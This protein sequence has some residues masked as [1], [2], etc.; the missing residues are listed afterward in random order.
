MFIQACQPPKSEVRYMNTLYPLTPIHWNILSIVLQFISKF[1]HLSLYCL[2]H[3]MT[4]STANIVYFRCY[5]WISTYDWWNDTGRRKMKYWKTSLYQCQSVH[6]K[7]H[8]GVSLGL[9][10]ERLERSADMCLFCTVIINCRKLR[11]H[12]AQQASKVITV[13]TFIQIHQIVQT[14][15]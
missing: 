6:N 10:G 2:C 7:C 3:L 5:R 14:M 12:N 15:K 11:K 1:V 13:A 4:L 9:Q 8:M